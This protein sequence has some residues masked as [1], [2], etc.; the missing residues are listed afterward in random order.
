MTTIVDSGR[1]GGPPSGWRGML[2]RLTR[3]GAGALILRGASLGVSTRIINAGL[4]LLTHVLLARLMGA[5]AFGIYS[6]AITFIL[7][8]TV[9]STLGLAMTPQRFVPAYRDGAKKPLLRG[10]FRFTHAAP[11]V[12][13]VVAA[14]LV[15]AVLHLAG[16][17]DAQTRLVIAIVL[18]GLPALALIDVVE[19]FALAHEWTG[20]AYGVTY[21][22][23]PLL[24]LGLALGMWGLEGRLD[25]VGAAKA[26]AI[27][28][29]IAA[30]VLVF[31][32][33]RRMR[34][35]LAEGGSPGEVAYAP[36]AWMSLAGPALLA[37]GAIVLMAYSDVLVLSLFAAPATIGIY[38]AVSRLVG[39][40]AFVHYGIGHASAHHFAAFHEAGDRQGLLA[41]ARRSAR[42]T[43]W[44]SL[45]VAV[46]VVAAGPWLLALFGPGFDAGMAFMPLLA[47]V[48]LLRAAAGPIEHLLMMSDHA[49]L[50][51][52]IYGAAAIANIGLSLVLAPL[53]G[54]VGVAG[55]TVI[56]VGGASLA[57]TIAARRVLGGP[58]HAFA[59][60]PAQAATA[61]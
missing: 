19:G 59:R 56:A 60:E 38:V 61:G 1:Q 49:R 9:F 10:L 3:D 42:W 32:L 25:A 17:Y 50:I 41:A 33:Y 12:G 45:A 46:A 11:L 13:G 43:F 34:P 36:R 40:I 39:L 6:L 8:L 15:L 5:K 30:L 14:A 2:A 55:A 22:T 58:V 57:A 7:A 21:L 44:P 23:R 24:L 35:R 52:L 51:T 48:F 26:F 29:W 47:L 4:A 16:A 37:D 54:A 31:E 18:I 28:A 53:F 27:A 20:L